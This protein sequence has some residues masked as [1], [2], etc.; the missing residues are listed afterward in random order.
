MQ[1]G[2]AFPANLVGSRRLLPELQVQRGFDIG[3]LRR[4]AKKRHRISFSRRKRFVIAVTVMSWRSSR[5]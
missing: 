1:R 5:E 3:E 4:S 2:H